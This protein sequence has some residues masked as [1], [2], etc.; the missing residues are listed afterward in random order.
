MIHSPIAAAA[1]EIAACPFC[2]RAPE[3]FTR[4]STLGEDS[5]T[6]KVTFISCKCGGY[7][8]RA[9]QYGHTEAE[10]IAAWNR[11]TGSDAIMAL[12]FERAA[13]VCEGAAATHRE[14]ADIH[15]RNG[16][17]APE[18]GRRMAAAELMR[19][20]EAIRSLS[21]SISDAVE[22]VA[23]ALYLYDRPKMFSGRGADLPWTD[24]G[25]FGQT[26]YRHKASAAIRT[27]GG[28]IDDR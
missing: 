13:K 10:V 2:G 12:A 22:R 28:K 15:A 8:A 1:E 4:A 18:A 23:E 9:H 20:A 5:P 24:L 17:E 25:E 14:I 19:L 27:M 16:A 3:M 7:S 6:G 21:P 11:R 26:I